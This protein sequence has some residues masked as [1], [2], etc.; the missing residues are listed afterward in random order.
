VGVLGDGMGWWA[1]QPFV[2]NLVSSIT[3]FAFAVPVA[4]LILSRVAEARG[5]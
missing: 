2:T 5:L 1:S 4:L 3:G